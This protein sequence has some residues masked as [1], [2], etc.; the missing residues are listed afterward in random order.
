[1]QG[2]FQPEEIE[3]VIFGNGSKSSESIVR[4]PI[5]PIELLEEKLQSSSPQEFLTF[6]SQLQEANL[7]YAEQSESNRHR[8][9]EAAE[10]NRHKEEIGRQKTY[11]LVMLFIAAIVAS[12][13]LYSG[14]SKDKVV[15]EK[16]ISTLTAL[17]AGAGGATVLQ[18]KQER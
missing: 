8:E 12:C 14:L 18:R 11:R 2:D 17:M 4:T 1:M 5:I 10:Q 15:S 3:E 13:F 7:N 6:F 16:V 9:V